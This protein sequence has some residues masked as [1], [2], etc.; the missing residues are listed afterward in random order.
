MNK[1]RRWIVS[2]LIVAVLALAG[3][4]GYQRY[5]APLPP[6]PT[7]TSTLAPRPG[8]VSAEASVVPR[9]HAALAFRNGGKV[10]EVLVRPGD[11]VEAGQPLMRLESDDLKAT[12][13]Q[14]EAGL[15]TA[16]ARLAQAEAGAR[17]E[18]IAA[19]RAN[20]EAAQA[21]LAQAQ[22]ALD[23][24]R[25]G[26]RPEQIAGAQAQLE[27][28][29][30]QLQYAEAVHDATM[31]GFGPKEWQ[32]RQQRE[33]ARAGVEE[34]QANLDLLKAGPTRE[35]LRQAQ[36][37]TQA[38]AAQVKASQAQLDLLLAGPRAE[39]LA[40]LRAGVAQ[41][42]AALDQARA[43]LAQAELTAP[44]AGTVADVTPEVGEVIAPGA[45]VVTLADLSGWQVETKDL[46]EVDVVKV[47]PGQ[48]VS[49][50]LDAFP[51]RV[52][53]GRVARVAQVSSERRGDIVYKVTVD[54]DDPGVEL[55]WD[56]TAFVD[57]Q[58]GE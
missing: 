25:A 33:A 32:A 31:Q 26:A 58:V 55:R 17:T 23:K 39:D 28:A 47:K 4:V 13:T 40:V 21:V 3:F 15:E 1:L 6:T 19:A 38:A 45:P 37:S 35:E 7:P 51:G 20:V 8:S 30:A 53:S 5:L 34:A 9:R 50:T 18:E 41:A 52:F 2:A 44:F 14:A 16:Q 27:A 24:L 46:S 56:M 36:A 22:A 43:V 48:P 54:L 57:I 10:A 42:Q 49:V 11:T 29:Q 12:V